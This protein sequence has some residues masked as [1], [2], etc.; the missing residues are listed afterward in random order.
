MHRKNENG[1]FEFVRIKIWSKIEK[2]EKKN[3]KFL[4]I[5]K[6]KK[7]KKLRFLTTSF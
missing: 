1:V 4:K 6:L 2:V 3:V 7:L 5:K